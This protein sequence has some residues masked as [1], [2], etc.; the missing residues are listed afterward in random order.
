MKAIPIAYPRI[1]KNGSA[2]DV[3]PKNVNVPPV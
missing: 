2:W 3:S 1:T